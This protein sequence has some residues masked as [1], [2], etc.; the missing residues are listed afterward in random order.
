M[1][2]EKSKFNGGS[3]FKP[4]LISIAIAVFISGCTSPKERRI[5]PK[6]KSVAKTSPKK[7][8]FPKV[9]RKKEGVKLC[10][11]IKS[12]TK[13]MSLEEVHNRLGFGDSKK[14]AFTKPI[15]YIKCYEADTI[16]SYAD[17]KFFFDEGCTFRKYYAPDEKEMEK[18]ICDGSA[19]KLA[20]PEIFKY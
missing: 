13:G 11:N 14:Y 15:F 12:L 10:K 2:D 17:F 6:K 3:M 8:S 19:G 18:M 7:T 1:H 20:P 4:I 5:T 9:D 16:I